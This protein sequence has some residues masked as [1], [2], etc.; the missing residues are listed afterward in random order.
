MVKQNGFLILVHLSDIELYYTPPELIKENRLILADDEFHHSVNVLR[1]SVADIIYVTDGNGSIFNCKIETIKE[2][3]LH[4]IIFEKRVFEN[5]AEKIWFCIPMLKNPD[6]LKFALEKCVELGITNF[7]LFSSRYTLSKNVKPEKFQKTALAA[8]KQSLRA[9]LPQIT[10]G[11]FNEIIH[12]DGMKVIFEQN[13]R[14]EFDGKVDLN[15]LTYY[16]FGP[17]GGFDKNEIESLE[18]GNRFS[19]STNRL[20]SETAIIK[21]ASLLKI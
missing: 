4:A 16:L 18:Q 15:K 19:L 1:N 8:M 9:F 2:K 13:S 7:I 11:G 14:L 10:S 6:R 5:K 21:C 12:F 3:Q 20:R 17:E